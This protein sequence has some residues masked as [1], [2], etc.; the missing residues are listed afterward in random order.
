MLACLA[1]F[2]AYRAAVL[3]VARARFFGIVSNQSGDCLGLPASAPAAAP[4]VDH[5]I[6]RNASS[7]KPHKTSAWV[8]VI[9]APVRAAHARK[10]PIRAAAPLVQACVFAIG[11]VPAFVNHESGKIRPC[12]RGEMH[13][14]ARVRVSVADGIGVERGAGHRGLMTG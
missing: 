8:V 6:E 11:Q 5:R 13:A 10:M 7:R 1:V 12:E 4:P 9:V 14:V 2:M 3:G